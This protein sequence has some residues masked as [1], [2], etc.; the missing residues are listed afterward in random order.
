MILAEACNSWSNEAEQGLQEPLLD[1][2]GALKGSNWQSKPNESDE[3][4]RVVEGNEIE[5]PNDV[6]VYNSETAVAHL[7][8]Q[9]SLII[10][11]IRLSQ[12]RLDTLKEKSVRRDIDQQS[13]L[14]CQFTSEFSQI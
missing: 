8:G 7:V 9:P 6:N 12:Q 4:Q 2:F 14:S 1:D 13:Y 10:L 3:L 5:D 11:K